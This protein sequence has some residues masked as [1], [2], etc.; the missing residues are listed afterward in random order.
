MNPL[1]WKRL[2]ELFERLLE[3]AP[4][5]RANWLESNE[6]DTSLREL[7]VAVDTAAH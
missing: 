4:E 7:K 3:Q 6:S 1:R 2:Q 5:E